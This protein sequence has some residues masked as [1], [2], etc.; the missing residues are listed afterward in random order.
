MWRPEPW[1][2]PYRDSNVAH[3][4]FED[5]AHVMLE[6]LKKTESVY[7]GPN[8]KSSTSVPYDTGRKYGWWVFIPDENEQ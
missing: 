6:A 5:G 7:I 1:H 2:N 3:Q 4:A 8:G